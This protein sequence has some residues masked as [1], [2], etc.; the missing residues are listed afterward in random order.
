MRAAC[1]VAVLVGMTGIARAGHSKVKL[2]AWLGIS[3][4]EQDS[5]WGGV[6]IYDV[7]DDTPASLCGLRAG[8]EILAIDRVDVHGASELQATIAEHDVGDRVTVAYVRRGDVRK[9]ATRLA[10]QVTDPTELLE[11]RL[12]GKTVPPLSLTRRG[13]GSALDDDTIRDRVVVLGLFSTS[14]DDCA[15]TLSELATRLA[16]DPD[17][18]GA[19]FTAVSV[20]GDAALDAYVQRMGVTVDLASDNGE[21][22]RRY[23]QDIGAVTILVVDH[24]GV[25]TFAASGPGPDDT[26]LDGAVYAASRAECARMK[27]E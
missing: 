26:Q 6:D 19:S 12:V 16:A 22:V 14:C 15:A 18:R 7:F 4:D 11:R 27:D 17:A 1:V 13:D 3:L 24:H 9:C 21:L 8:D 25:V 2:H 23:L 20:G 10:P 5:A